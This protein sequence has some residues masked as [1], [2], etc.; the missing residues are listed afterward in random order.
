MANLIQKDVLTV[1]MINVAA[2]VPFAYAFTY[3]EVV[4]WSQERPILLLILIVIGVVLSFVGALLPRYF[5]LP[6]IRA[7]STFAQIVAGSILGLLIGV[8]A[9]VSGAI[10]ADTTL[11]ALLIW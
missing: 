10:A 4:R 1:A 8:V 7:Q 11:W 2:A 9:G 6:S 5:P 3:T